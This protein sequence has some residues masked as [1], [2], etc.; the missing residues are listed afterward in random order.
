MKYKKILRG[1][2]ISLALTL[3]ISTVTF[4]EGITYIPTVSLA[5]IS[6]S[7]RISA[8]K[9]SVSKPSSSKS[10]TKSTSKPSTSSKSTTKS[11]QTTNKA[12]SSSKPSTS[13][14][15]KSST[16]AKPSTSNT[17]KNSTSVKPSTSRSNINTSSRVFNN[18]PP[19]YSTHSVSN[20]Y[21]YT[22][23]RP[24][25]FNNFLSH[26]FLYRLMTPHNRVY[27]TDGGAMH[28][29]SAYTGVKSIFW[30]VV[31]FITV[32]ALVIFVVRFIRRRRYR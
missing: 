19:S 3:S 10:I 27:Y 15:S 22:Q 20:N 12:S 26:Y 30:D 23:S 1:L 25:Y 4:A 18:I 11:G 21:Y 7:A 31:T 9:S 28:Y 13:N 8:P 14:S 24:S 5:K 2:L 32:I 17:Y 16:V 6:S 29:A